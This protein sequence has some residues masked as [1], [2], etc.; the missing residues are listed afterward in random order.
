MSRGYQVNCVIRHRIIRELYKKRIKELGSL[1]SD[2]SVE[3]KIRYVIDNLPTLPGKQ[4]KYSEVR[5]RQIINMSS[6]AI[7]AEEEMVKEALFEYDNPKQ[8]V[9]K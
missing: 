1:A 7:E 2:V 4:K 6:K 3:S 9:N 5:I 8:T